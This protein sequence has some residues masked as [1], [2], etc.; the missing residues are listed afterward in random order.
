MQLGHDESSNLF[1]TLTAFGMDL[2]LLS[3]QG[4]LLARLQCGDD[5]LSV[6]Q[7]SAT[8]ILV[9]TVKSSILFTQGFFVTR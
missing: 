8:M 9:H 6:Q 1:L 4:K 7:P 5:T 2:L 3:A